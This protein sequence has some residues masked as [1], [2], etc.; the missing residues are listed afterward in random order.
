MLKSVCSQS[1]IWRIV[2]YLFQLHLEALWFHKRA[3]YFW[4]IWRERILRTAER[5]LRYVK[6]S[7]EIRFQYIFLVTTA[8]DLIL[9]NNSNKTWF[10][11]IL[12]VYLRNRNIFVQVAHNDAD[13]LSQAGA[14]S[15]GKGC[16][17]WWRHRSFS[18]YCGPLVNREIC[19]V[20]ET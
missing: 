9:R 12:T 10:V 2:Q 19:F 11:Q 14:W 15:A 6:P 17:L 3:C 13:V 18:A 5:R 16:S 1:N 20:S 8:Q 7:S 4:W